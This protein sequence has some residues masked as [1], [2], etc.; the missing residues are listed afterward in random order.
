MARIESHFVA[1]L[2]LLVL[3]AMFAATPGY[4]QNYSVLYDFGNRS[5]E[6]A[7]PNFSGAIAQGRDG[8]M[9]TTSSNGGANNL[10]AVFEISPAGQLRVRYSFCSQ[11]NCADGSNPTG[12]TLGTDGN[13]YGATLFGGTCSRIGGCGTVFQVTPTG[14]LA[15]LYNFTSGNDGSFPV[16]PPIR[17]MDGTFYGTASL[18]GASSNCGTVYRITPTGVFTL[19]HQFDGIDGCQPN[20]TLVRVGGNFFGTTFNGGTTYGASLGDGVVFQITP[21]GSVT[22]LYNFDGTHGIEPRSPLVQGS[23]GDFYGTT[24]SNSTGNSE[25]FKMTPPGT[26]LYTLNGT[27]DG[28]YVNAGLV[29][30]TDGNFYGVASEGGN[31]ACTHGCGT[32][33]QI[34]PA[35][36]YSV[37]YSFDGISGFAPEVTPF[38]HTN[39]VLYGDTYYGGTGKMCSGGGVGEHCGLFYSW[40]GNLPPFVALL[41]YSG[42]VG[43]TIEFLGQGFTSASTVS[44]NGVPATVASQGNSGTY[45]RA[46]VPSGATTGFVTVTTSTGTLTSNKQFVVIP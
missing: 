14:T 7:N 1:A 23:D 26:V 4:A 15:V 43:D 29:Q 2:V 38:Q 35:G 37:L 22:V 10:G 3:V 32:L 9:Y 41:P 25:V 11:A 24:I 33:F 36:S 40:N 8:N 46:M 31:S 44:F 19:L 27:T 30:A 45:L 6:P 18:K 42:K 21:G 5:G 12:L 13:F 34:T 16:A 17:G 39:G 20:A 28:A